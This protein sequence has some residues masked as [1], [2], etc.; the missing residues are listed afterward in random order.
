MEVALHH[1]PVILPSE[2]GC[3]SDVVEAGDIDVEE[4]GDGVS[5][6]IGVAM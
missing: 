5:G 3:G 4:L 6:V 1:L 2:E